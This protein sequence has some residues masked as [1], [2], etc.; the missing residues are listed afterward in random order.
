MKKMF[1]TAIVVS[2]VLLLGA[3]STGPGNTEAS[4]PVVSVSA[5]PTATATPKPTP[6][7]SPTT[8]TELDKFDIKFKVVNAS[9]DKPLGIDYEKIPSDNT[10]IPDE[11][12]PATDL[13]SKAEIA[14]AAEV[15]F[16]EYHA[17]RI[18]PRLFKSN[19]T[20]AGDI[21]IVKDYED[22][23]GAPLTE[24]WASDVKAKN[25]LGYVAS[26]NKVSDS[27]VAPG[28]KAP[29]GVKQ[30]TIDPSAPKH[31]IEY[32]QP[33]VVGGYLEFNG[34]DAVGFYFFEEEKH[35]LVG[36]GEGRVKWENEIW[37]QPDNKGN[38][39]V[40]GMFANVVDSSLP[41]S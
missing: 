11:F 6:K 24:N 23:W 12:F 34:E 25:L 39:K 21:A 3:C 38:W 35:A 1:T 33:K 40:Q 10:R 14:E 41:S 28:E 19:R 37:M 30:F 20:P 17:L 2:S 36:G 31:T 8:S 9:K 29:K 13:F 15:A 26:G 22:K 7:P 4:D 27:Y 5:S 16:A 32:I 18:D